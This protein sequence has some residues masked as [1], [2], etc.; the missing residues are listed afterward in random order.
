M[1]Q[2]IQ[3]VTQLI[4]SAWHKYPG[5]DVFVS[6]PYDDWHKLRKYIKEDH[7]ITVWPKDE[8][9]KENFVFGGAAMIMGDHW[10][11]GVVP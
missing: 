3:K 4:E 11:N 6:L 10:G 2:L 5:Q 1:D 9:D 8:F 7:R